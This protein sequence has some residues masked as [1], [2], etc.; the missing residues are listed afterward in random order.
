[1][2]QKLNKTRQMLVDSYI[3]SLEEDRIPWVQDWENTS[4]PRNAVTNNEYN[5]ANRLLLTYLSYEKEYKD[6]RWC[7]FNQIMDA[8]K[9]HPK[10]KWHLKKDSKGVPIEYWY[11]YD[12]MNR[13][14]YSISEFEKLKKEDPHIGNFCVLTGRTYYV[15]NAQ[16]IEGIPPLEIQKFSDIEKNEF[17]ENMINN[18][19]VGFEEYGDQAFYS[20]N[21]D[22]V[23]VPL[24]EH[25]KDSYGYHSTVLHELS[26]ASG[27]PSRLNRDISGSFG[28]IDY[29]KEELRAEIGSSFVMQ[30]L[31]IPYDQQ[32]IQNHK[33][34]IQSWIKVFKKDK[35]EL[36]K[37]INDASKI[38]DYLKEKG[39]I[40]KE[41]DRTVTAEHTEKENIAPG[42]DNNVSIAQ[43]IKNAKA[44]ASIQEKN[45]GNRSKDIPQR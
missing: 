23:T 18:M 9:Y 12:K 40:N 2:T 4:T 21:K 1:M 29:A 8:E 37:A 43:R 27:H 44:K 38:A 36:F 32:H 42:N 41:I 30:E 15:F 20:L 13:K 35:N 14:S 28:S 34:Y 45:T 33:A 17:M 22:K 11:I 25:F 19:G 7:T 39:N 3:K 24:K 5:G 6:P 10:E 26:H 16:D 31:N